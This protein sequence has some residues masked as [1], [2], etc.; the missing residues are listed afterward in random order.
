MPPLSLSRIPFILDARLAAGLPGLPV[1]FEGQDFTPPAGLWLRPVCQPGQ[2]Q[3]DEKGEQGWSRRTGLYLVDVI[4][5]CH[6]AA[7]LGHVTAPADA[8]ELAARVEELFRRE[9][10]A[11]PAGPGVLQV[12]DPYSTN[13]GLN[14][15]NAFQV[16]VTVPWWAWAAR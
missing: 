4:A 15:Q 13:L 6:G 5:P 2:M 14:E 9:S 7:S 1:A 8:W 3:G 11:D 16:R 10:L 12:E